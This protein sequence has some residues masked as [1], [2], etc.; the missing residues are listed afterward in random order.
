[1]LDKHILAKAELRPELKGHGRSF[2]GIRTL[3][4]ELHVESLS[5]QLYSKIVGRGD[6]MGLGG[7]AD[8]WSWPAQPEEVEERHTA[9]EW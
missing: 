7:V 3:L 2:L 8:K 9:E 1:M 5:T 4:E 6:A